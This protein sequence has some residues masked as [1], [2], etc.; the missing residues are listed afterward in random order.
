MPKTVLFTINYAPPLS[1]LDVCFKLPFIPRYTHLIVKSTAIYT[2]VLMSCL[3]NDSNILKIR[4]AF[5]NVHITTNKFIE[6]YY[7]SDE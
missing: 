4:F 3:Y 2:A 7:R 6:K 1:S 5:H